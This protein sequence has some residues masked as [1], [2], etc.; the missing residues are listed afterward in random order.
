ME[1]G[2]FSLLTLPDPTIGSVQ[3][4]NETREQVRLAEQVGFDVAW[5]AEHHFSNY[6]I[7]TSPLLLVAH[8][9]QATSTIKLGTAVIVLPFYEPLRLAQDVCLTDAL[10]GGRLVLGFGFGYQPREFTTFGLDIAQ[11]Y[12]RGIEVWDLVSQAVETAR[13]TGHPPHTGPVDVSIAVRPAHHPIETYVVGSDREVIDRAAATGA[14]PFVTLGVAPLDAALRQRDRF[15]EAYRSAGRAV[16]PFAMQRYVHIT[17]DRAEMRA[18]S[19]QVRRILRM[20]T[21]LRRPVPEMSGSHLGEP[22]FECEPSLE[23]IEAAALIGPPGLIAERIV[24]EAR[25]LGLSHLSCFMR[26][27]A[28]PHD[29]TMRSIERFGIEVAPVLRAEL[30]EVPDR[31][32]RLSR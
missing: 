6:S 27:A 1:L 11:R 29:V 9:A 22:A 17:D 16:M 23:E 21:N 20:A 18:A 2:L 19:E 28:A 13:M 8:M 24:D 32:A 3:L 31:G 12:T 25:T 26:L 10:T 5:F 15:A 7:A 30:P 14:T 4:I